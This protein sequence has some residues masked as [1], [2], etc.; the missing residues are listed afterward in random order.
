MSDSACYNDFFYTPLGWSCSGGD[1]GPIRTDLGTLI[2]N[3]ISLEGGRST[4]PVGFAYAVGPTAPEVTDLSPVAGLFAYSITAATVPEPGTLLLLL[5][6]LSL[7]ALLRRQSNAS[8][9]VKAR[10]TR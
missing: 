8:Q 5:S 4:F 10:I 7:A 1:I 6:G 2:G 3:V 9:L